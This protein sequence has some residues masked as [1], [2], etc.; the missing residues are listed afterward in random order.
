MLKIISICLVC[1][2]GFSLV[3]CST[4]A[5]QKEMR[6]RKYSHIAEMNRRAMADD[7]DK[8]LLLDRASML[9]EWILPHE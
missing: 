5:T 7:V 4:S 2:T 9:S 1:A 8:L 6:Y 3:G